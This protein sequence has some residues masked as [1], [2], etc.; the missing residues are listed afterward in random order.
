MSKESKSTSAGPRA[1]TEEEMELFGR[2]APAGYESEAMRYI[3]STGVLDGDETIECKEGRLTTYE[4]RDGKKKMVSM[5]IASKLSLDC[6]YI[7]A[8]LA[9]R[10][11]QTMA[12][13]KEGHFIPLLD[14]DDEVADGK[15]KTINLALGKTATDFILRVSR[16]PVRFGYPARNP[17]T[18]TVMADNQ[19]RGFTLGE[20]IVKIERYYAFIEQ[21]GTHWDMESNTLLNSKPSKTPFDVAWDSAGNS[22]AYLVYSETD[23]V[24][25]VERASWS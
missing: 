10:D 5:G 7:Q 17:V 23:K 20:L 16:V 21:V 22:I 11:P 18:F 19:L 9:K 4:I 25:N 24:W 14:D 2:P 6:A 8:F 15:N 1:A 13:W 3:K 12:T